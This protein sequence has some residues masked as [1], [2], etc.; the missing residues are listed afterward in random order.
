MDRSEYNTKREV[1]TMGMTDRQFSSYIRLILDLL[2]EIQKEVDP[3]H[4]NAKLA[5]LIAHLQDSI[6]E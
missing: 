6:E 1:K 5:R 3:K 4:E 2:A